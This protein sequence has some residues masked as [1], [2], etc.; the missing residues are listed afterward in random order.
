MILASGNCPIFNAN[1]AIII[2]LAPSPTY[3]LGT[4]RL[5]N[6]KKKKLRAQKC[7]AVPLRLAMSE[8]CECCEHNVS[9]KSCIPLPGPRDLSPYEAIYICITES[10]HLVAHPPGPGPSSSPTSVKYVKC[11]ELYKPL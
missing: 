4:V 1:I 2:A 3:D 11:H 9:S 10:P 5:V 7:T 8:T 6:W